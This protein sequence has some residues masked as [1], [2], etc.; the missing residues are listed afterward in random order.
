MNCFRRQ[1][2]K[3]VSTVPETHCISLVREVEDL[4][5]DGDLA[6]LMEMVEE[7]GFTAVLVL[8]RRFCIL[9]K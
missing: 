8:F 7:L 6:E 5:S 2:L 4:T 1:L 3:L 9:G